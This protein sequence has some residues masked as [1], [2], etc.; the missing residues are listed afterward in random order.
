[1]NDRILDP[2]GARERLEAWKG[3]I[4]KLAADTQTMSSRLQAVRIT[5]NDPT[6]L[7]EV[8]IDSTGSLVNLTLTDRIHRVPPTVVA[9]TIMATLGRARTT[10]SEQSQEI[11]ADTMGT[12]SPTAQAVSASV[13]RQLRGE[14]PPHPGSSTDEDGEDFDD[15]SYLGRR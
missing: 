11:I 13:G 1:M 14:A 9:E 4:D 12:E 3:R 10:L 8:T 7:T 2:G 5:T 15:R 6:G